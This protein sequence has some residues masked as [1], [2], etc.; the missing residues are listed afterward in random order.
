MTILFAVMCAALAMFAAGCSTGSGY[1]P[2]TW[3]GPVV[4]FVINENEDLDDSDLAHYRNSEHPIEYYY[5]KLEEGQGIKI[6][7]PQTYS[8]EKITRANYELTG[9]FKTRTQTEDGYAYSDE[10]DF[11]ADELTENK[12][13]TLYARWERKIKYTY[14]LC[15]KDADGQK[16]VV[17]TYR[18]ISVGAKFNDYKK[19]YERLSEYN[20]TAIYGEDGNCF[21]YDENDEP[22]DAD[23]GHPGGETDTAIDVYVHWVEGIYKLV[24]NANDFIAAKN[25]GVYLMADIDMAGTTFGGFCDS[26]NPSRY[27][28]NFEGN[29]KT[30]SNLNLVFDKT[31]SLSTDS[32]LGN[33]VLV[34]SLFANLNGAKV[35]NVT[36]KDVTVEIDTDYSRITQIYLV[37]ITVRMYQ[38]RDNLHD[39]TVDS[40]ITGVHYTGTYKLTRLPSKIDV[41][42]PEKFHLVT[43]YVYYKDGEN[44]YK[45]ATSTVDG[46]TV[47]FTEEVT[48]TANLPVNITLY[49][50]SKKEY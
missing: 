10:W 40:A 31:A 18:N 19:S 21:Y 42:D 17:D 33:N 5:K 48:A 9:W 36:F 44:D 28:N 41:N 6:S 37:P 23:F 12:V 34:A 8:G 4:M 20:K 29:N 7:D 16:V 14:N 38:R 26:S 25:S 43:D 30:V 3:D 35:Q 11:D 13:Y 47:S 49:Y 24:Y 2:E 1:N 50:N 45:D 27:S 39:I 15:F 22:W 32:L 46:C